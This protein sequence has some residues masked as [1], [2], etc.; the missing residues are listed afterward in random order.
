MGKLV[1]QSADLLRR[2]L[3]E[4]VEL[5]TVIGVTRHRALIDPVQLENAILNLGINARD[6]MPEGGTLTIEVTNADVSLDYAHAE[7]GIRPGAYVVVSLTDT[8]TGMAADVRER[9]FEPFF[10][11]KPV[12]SGTGLGLSMVYGF[13]RQS[14]G[15]VQL[16]SAPGKGT[17]VRMYFPRTE[18]G[19]A[20]TPVDSAPVSLPARGETV[21]VVEDDARVRDVT[22]QRLHK[23]GYRVIEAENGAQGL[24]QLRASR[25]V[26]LLFTDMVMPG[27]M[28]GADLAERAR[29]ERPDLKILFTSGYAE[30][31]VVRKGGLAT[32]H[33]LPKPHSAAELARKLREALES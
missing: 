25:D 20:E 32:A 2:A 1:S 18:E 28:S 11:T 17:I 8:G 13:V 19:V 26:D 24:E 16:E 6:A 22:V 7:S 9:A 29:A 31:E 10:T 4:S 14:G 15:Q 27:G 5:R 3:G 23:L 21:L 12:G 33:W 30:P